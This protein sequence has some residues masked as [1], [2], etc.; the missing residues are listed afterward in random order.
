MLS[1]GWSRNGWAGQGEGSP[2]GAR[3]SL[4]SS[5]GAFGSSRL[6]MS[7]AGPAGGPLPL[8]GPAAACFIATVGASNF[9]DSFD[10][11]DQAG[12]RS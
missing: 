7:A 3:R 6:R 11:P 5:R 4:S 2:G 8:P 9:A 1:T 12:A 10:E